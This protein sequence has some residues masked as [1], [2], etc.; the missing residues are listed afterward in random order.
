MSKP[1][2][3]RD[4]SGNHYFMVTL[5]KKWTDSIEKFEQTELKPSWSGGRI[6][7]EVITSD[8]QKM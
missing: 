6:V 5:P 4:Y 2:V 8:V 1:C 3:Y 7:F